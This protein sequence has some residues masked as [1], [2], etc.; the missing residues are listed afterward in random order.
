MPGSA[1]CRAIR[2]AGRLKSVAAADTLD[3]G[4]WTALW[5]SLGA[6]GDGLTVFTRL[7][8]A[9][10][11]AARAYHTAA[12]IQDCLVQ[13]D[14]SRTTARRPEEVEAALWFHDAVYQ[15]D[16]SDNEDRSAEIARSTLQEAG[17]SSKEVERVAELILATRHTVIPSDPDA[18]LLCDIDLS[19]LGRSP[20]VFNRYERQIRR[21]YAWVPDFK[22]RSTRSE[23]LQRFLQRRS[24]YQT[25]LFRSRYEVPARANLMRLLKKLGA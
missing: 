7:A 21:E 13:L 9:Y 18:A 20:V 8:A 12:H 15:P 6:H 23:I 4:R 1:A 25:S 11:D 14:L 24:I 3:I 2:T 10:G 22:Y 17:V 16:R 19:I 5:T